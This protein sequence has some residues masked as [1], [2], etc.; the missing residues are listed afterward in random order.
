MQNGLK[1]IYIYPFIRIVFKY[2]DENELMKR[3]IKRELNIYADK[4]KTQ[5]KIGISNKKV[6]CALNNV[7]GIL[8]IKALII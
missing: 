1:P 3:K 5:G 2:Q 6:I 4:I 7:K 8:R